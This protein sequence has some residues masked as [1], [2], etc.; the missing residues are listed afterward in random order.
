M[1][2][3]VSSGGVNAPHKKSRIFK[4]ISL[5]EFPPL[6]SDFCKKNIDFVRILRLF[7]V[8]LS[9]NEILSAILLFIVGFGLEGENMN[10]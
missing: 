6:L 1:N 9:E 10:I 8:F 4:K 2:R 7:D 5:F 3:C